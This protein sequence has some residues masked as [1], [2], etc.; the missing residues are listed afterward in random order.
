MNKL[1]NKMDEKQLTIKKLAELLN[2]SAYR[3]GEKVN[4]NRFKVEEI[5]IILKILDCKYEDLFYDV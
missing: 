2:L 3:C 1:K 4:I 5:N